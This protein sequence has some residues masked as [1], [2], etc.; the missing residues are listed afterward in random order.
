M[1]LEQ[2]DVPENVPSPNVLK[3]VIVDR[4]EIKE[5]ENS[6][7]EKCIARKNLV[8]LKTHN[9]S[10]SAVQAYIALKYFILYS[11]EISTTMAP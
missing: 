7:G 5:K 9:T 11:L 4:N 3:N 2:L 1:Q 8:Y 6:D 10:S